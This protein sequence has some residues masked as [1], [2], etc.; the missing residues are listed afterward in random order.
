MIMALKRERTA[1][2]AFIY[3]D[4]DYGEYRVEFH[5][6]MGYMRQFDYFTSDKQDAMDTAEYWIAG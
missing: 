4:R 1:R 6:A 5:D 3:F 2:K